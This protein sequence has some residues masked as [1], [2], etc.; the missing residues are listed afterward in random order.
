MGW[1]PKGKGKGIFR[2]DGVCACVCVCWNRGQQGR[3]S[4]ESYTFK[5]EGKGK[6]KDH[7]KGFKDGFKEGLKGETFKGKGRGL[8]SAMGTGR[9]HATTMPILSHPAF[10]SSIS[11][12]AAAAHEP[13]RAGRSPT[14]AH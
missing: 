10:C 2:F 3:R 9:A 5:G 12:A 8:S 1:Q 14:A 4:G 7:G 6:T 11:V 13:G